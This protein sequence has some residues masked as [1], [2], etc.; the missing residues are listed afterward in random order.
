MPTDYLCLGYSVCGD[1]SDMELYCNNTIRCPD[2]ED[3][4]PRGCWKCGETPLGR[5]NTCNCSGA[6][7]KW[8]GYFER[9]ERCCTH[10]Q[11][12]EE[13]CRLKENGDVSCDNSFLCNDG[14]AYECGELWLSKENNCFCSAD[15]SFTYGDYSEKNMACCTP[16][17]GGEGQCRMTDEGDVRCSNGALYDYGTYACNG[18]CADRAYYGTSMKTNDTYFVC[19]N[20]KCVY[21]AGL[22]QG[23]TFCEDNSDVELY[24]NNTVG[25]PYYPKDAPRGCWKCG[26]TPIGRDKTCNCSGATIKWDDYVGITTERCC[27]HNQK[28]EES[29]QTNEHGDVSCDNSFVCTDGG[30]AYQCGD[31]W[32]SKE[33]TCFCSAEQSLTYTDYSKD[34]LACC[35]PPGK[36]QCKRTHQGHVSCSNG[37]V[38]NHSNNLECKPDGQVDYYDEDDY[39]Y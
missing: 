24:C 8:D 11:K 4:A 29:C 27:T 3:G 6:S 30:E 7:I 25:C 28:G 12:G 36:G 19:T 22:C 10:N 38:Y 33:N 23:E 21:K 17:A 14:E 5:D 26:D 35:V 9:Y 2:S 15:Q 32:L 20:N 37:T 18:L 34:D 16:P 1:N 31:T 39:Y 13:K